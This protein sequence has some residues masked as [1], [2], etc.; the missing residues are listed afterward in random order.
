MRNLR[1]I[2]SVVLALALMA[3]PTASWAHISMAVGVSVNIAPPVLPVYVQPVCP[4]P[5]YIWTPGYWA[6]D[7]DTGYYW[8][9]GTWVL[10]PAVGLLWTP[11]Y[12]G[13]DVGIYMWHP[14]Y[15]GPHVGFYGGINYGFGYTGVGFWGGYWNHGGFYYNRSV[16]NINITNIPNV[17][18]R[19][20]VNNVSGTR[21][22]FNG[23][24]GITARPT[25]AELAVARDPHRP[26]TTMQTEHER[27]ASANRSQWASVNHGRPA[28]A[29]TA[30]PGAFNGRGV[31]AAT[32]RPTFHATAARAGGN[33]M[34]AQTPNR[35]GSATR[36]LTAVNPNPGAPP[37]SMAHAG[38][39]AS[40][41]GATRPT[42]ARPSGS[43]THATPTARPN[44]ARPSRPMAHAAPASRPSV[45]RPSQTMAHAAPVARPAPP[46]ASASRAPAPRA[47]APRPQSKPRQGAG[48]G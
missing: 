22:S 27:V 9:P 1:L 8:V 19:T 43:M 6:W 36:P 17:Y 18:N 45:A 23:P 3:V 48:R 10:A 15:W 31:V 24:G 29:A 14:G 47:P 13:W 20:V 25:P 32:N 33:R 35:G 37:R 12:W 26:A 34:T 4:A 2:R 42:P 41:N 44:A 38:A 7:P 40:R 16:N 5:G 46:R 28:V 39:P 21:A 11:G 30:K